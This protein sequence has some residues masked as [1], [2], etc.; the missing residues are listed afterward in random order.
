MNNDTKVTPKENSSYIIFAKDSKLQIQSD[1][2]KG[3]GTY[4]LKE[5]AFSVGPIMA[6]KMACLDSTEKEFFSNLSATTSIFM[7]NGFLYMD[8]KMDSGTMKFVE[9]K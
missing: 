2:N 3:S 9:K 4:T 7:S 5:K 1:C 6:T 8:L